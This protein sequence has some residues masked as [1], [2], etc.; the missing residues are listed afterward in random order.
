[1]FKMLNKKCRMR[2][3][4]TPFIPLKVALIPSINLKFGVTQ[5]SKSGFSNRIRD[6]PNA[7]SFSFLD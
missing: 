7:P 5:R 3:V 6:A 4:E 1:M 2:R